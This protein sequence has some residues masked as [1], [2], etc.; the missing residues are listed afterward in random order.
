M[1][2]IYI[3]MDEEMGENLLTGQE[4]ICIRNG[5]MNVDQRT[6]YGFAVKR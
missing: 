5:R 2:G 4:S 1:E 6:D 3:L